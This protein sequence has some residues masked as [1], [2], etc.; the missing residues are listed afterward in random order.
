[1]SCYLKFKIEKQQTT[2]LNISNLNGMKKQL[3]CENLSR[4]SFFLLVACITEYLFEEQAVISAVLLRMFLLRLLVKIYSCPV[5]N[6]SEENL[7]F[8]N[9]LCIY[10]F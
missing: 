10:L 4:V 8:T 7:I 2:I 5:Q 1:M 9:V 6:V 3:F